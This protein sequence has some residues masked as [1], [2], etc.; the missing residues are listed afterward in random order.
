MIIPF[1]PGGTVECPQILGPRVEVWFPHFVANRPAWGVC[2]GDTM[3]DPWEDVR[4]RLDRRHGTFA[5]CHKGQKGYIDAQDQVDKLLADADTL[6]AVVR[7]AE[8]VS[9][10]KTILGITGDKWRALE[11]ALAALPEH[12][13]G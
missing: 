7:A 10:G 3:S 6:L 13:K 11:K 9:K 12:L 5:Y 4:K 8:P 1:A 2:F